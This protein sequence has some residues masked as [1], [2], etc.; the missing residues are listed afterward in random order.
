MRPAFNMVFPVYTLQKYVYFRPN[1]NF[2][3]R[4]AG[5]CGGFAGL[6]SESFADWPKNR[7]FTKRKNFPK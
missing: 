3:G 6:R 5:R 2:A 7:I 1:P 4:T